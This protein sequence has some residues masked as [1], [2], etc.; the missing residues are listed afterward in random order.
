M[1]YRTALKQC[2]IA[3]L[4]AVLFVVLRPLAVNA[5]GKFSV[6]TVINGLA[7]ICSLEGIKHAPQ[8]PVLPEVAA[9]KPC[10]FCT[11]SVPVFADAY[12]PR[13]LA[14]VSTRPTVA[15]AGVVRGSRCARGRTWLRC[16][17]M[18]LSMSMVRPGPRW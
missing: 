10:V 14:V 13:L 11:S 2:A 6:A 1:F 8:A 12:A 7:E 5:S 17:S 4:L 18:K 9:H 16:T 3:T 15:Q